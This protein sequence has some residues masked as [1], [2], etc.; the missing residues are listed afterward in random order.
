[1]NIFGEGFPKEII[2][3]IEQRQARYGSNSRTTEELLYTNNKNG[4]CKLVSSVDITPRTDDTGRVVDYPDSASDRLKLIGIPSS[5][6]NNQLA[7]EFVLFNGTSTQNENG[8]LQ[9][10]G[11]ARDKS[12]VNNNV[13]GLGGLEFGLSPMPG[14]TSAEIKTLNRGSIKES[15]VQI[16]AFNRIQFQIIDA[17]YLRLGYPILLEWGHSAYFDNDGVYQSNQNWSIANEFLN[18][19][20]KD[21]FAILEKIRTTRLASHG[22][23]DA[24]LGKVKNF[25]WSF[26]KDGSY[27]IT[28]SI[29][30]IGD[31]IE[32]LNMNRSMNVFLSKEEQKEQEE[33]QKEA[34]DEISDDDFLPAFANTNELSKFFYKGFK[35]L[36]KQSHN[37]LSNIPSVPSFEVGDFRTIAI[38]ENDDPELY[39]G[40]TSDF[41]NVEFDSFGSEPDKI[42]IRFGTLLKAIEQ[43]CLIY[44]LKGEKTN[45]PIIKLDYD[46]YNYMYTSDIM[47]PCDPRVCIFRKQ[48]S[49][50]KKINLGKFES[51]KVYSLYEGT[52]KYKDALEPFEEKISDFK[53]GNI[54]NIY[55]NCRFILTKIKENQNE[56][57]EVPLIVLL[58]SICDSI[59]T[60]T[61][62]K[63]KLTPVI[64]EENNIIRII[65]ET[66][67]PNTDKIIEYINSKN[68]KIELNPKIANFDVYGYYGGFG[69]STSAGFIKDFSFTTEITPDLATLITVGATANGEVVGED[70]TAFSKWNVALKNR[71]TENLVDASKKKPTPTPNTADST[72]SPDKQ[73]IIALTAELYELL[74][75]YDDFVDNTLWPG[76]WEPEKWDIYSSTLSNIL[77]KHQALTSKIN[78]FIAKNQQEYNKTGASLKTGFIPFNINLTLEGMSGMKVYQQ[79]NMDSAFLPSNYPSTFKF[80]IKSVTHTIQD[81]K[82]ETKLETMAATTVTTSPASVANFL[83][84]EPNPTLPSGNV[85]SEGRGVIRNTPPPPPEL[86][87]AMKRYG[88][89]DSKEKAHFL[90]QCAHESGGFRWTKEFASGRAYEGRKDLGNVQPGDGVKFKGRG[91]IQITGRSNYTRYNNY[92]KSKGVNVNIL[93]TPEVVETPYYA[94]DSACYWWKF[95]SRNISLLALAGV[96]PSNVS[97]VSTRVNGGRPA[98]GLNDRQ[99]KFDKY[100]ADLQNNPLLYS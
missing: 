2:S 60:T 17:L 50:P 53:V 26:E 33:K 97:V 9:R 63:A 40:K 88:I 86:V 21:Y 3:Q 34:E 94:A 83:G 74:A 98:N 6:V 67:L 65:D 66:P 51:S 59:N 64:D 56:N 100:W 82:W 1:M 48:V 95:L 55:V 92:L 46:D 52:G 29:I 49:V 90:A 89:V 8:I 75:D 11:I 12:I 36:E 99:V 47:A 79:F 7:K 16:K 41:A 39:T 24:L 68:P 44:N 27:S 5:Y 30:S 61:G 20:L 77:S 32:S 35:L 58:Q 19:S 38:S 25:S 23:Y 70:A 62:N 14:I 15:T 57:G 73:A 37:L 71:I 81:N 22:N 28:L 80:L 72:D 76:D 91:Y 45:E 69:E 84:N 18:G 4:W 31:V 43:K 85:S 13:Y 87:E 42:Y 10:E 78:L 54:M 93:A 96:T